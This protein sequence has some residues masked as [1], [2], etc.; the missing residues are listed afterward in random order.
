MRRPGL[1]PREDS[2]TP[3]TTL[4]GGQRMLRLV[5][6]FA[7]LSLASC[8]F[9]HSVRRTTEL[10]PEVLPTGVQAA[11]QAHPCVTHVQP[12]NG[13]W[14]SVEFT[15]GD[16]NVV[17]LCWH[18]TLEAQSGWVNRDPEPAVLRRS[19]AMQAEVIQLLRERFPCLPPM[20]SWVLS[21]YHL[22][23]QPEAAGEAP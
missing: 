7:V 19:L 6:I 4:D 9:L 11:V 2:M 16:A 1:W 10:P 18:G 23:A 17:L 15:E 8:D 20:G 14:L 5:P 12:W 22:D 21:W 13:E 3:P